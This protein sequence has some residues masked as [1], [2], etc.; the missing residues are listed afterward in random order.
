[1]VK[2]KKVS[3]KQNKDKFKKLTT[4]IKKAEFCADL[5]TIEVQIFY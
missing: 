1:M 4:G 2:Y 3:K 5:E